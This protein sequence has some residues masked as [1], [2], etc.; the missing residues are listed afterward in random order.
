M[1]RVRNGSLAT[2]RGGCGLNPW[3]NEDHAMLQ[4]ATGRAGRDC[5]GASRREFLQVGTLALGGLSLAEF[6]S[7]RARAAAAGAASKDTAVVML[8]LSG[9][10]SQIETFDPKMTA[11]SEYRS[12]SGEVAGN[13]PGISL[14]G[15][16]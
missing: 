11:P 9:G 2:R 6:L 10:P 1:N 14:G 12:V 5:Q 16:F 3:A 7:A 4:I 15:T 13:V 8:F